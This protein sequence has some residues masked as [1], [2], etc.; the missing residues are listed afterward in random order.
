MTYRRKYYREYRRSGKRAA[1]RERSRLLYH[2]QRKA[3][4][5]AGKKMLRSGG[6]T[7]R[8]IP[9]FSVARFLAWV[10]SASLGVRIRAWLI[11]RFDLQSACPAPPLQYLLARTPSI[12]AH[13]LADALVQ[14]GYEKEFAEGRA[15]EANIIRMKG[16]T[17]ESLEIPLASN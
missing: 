5:L 8:R 10:E 11:V 2:R 4:G 9:G 12:P 7:A 13:V 16:K 14:I 3:S 6:S 1:E 15:S 17:V